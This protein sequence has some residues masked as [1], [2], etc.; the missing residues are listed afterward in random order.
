M[1]NGTLLSEKWIKSSI[2]GTIWAASEIVLG[3]FLHNLKIPF[4][5]TVL[6]SIGL[7]VL[8]STSYK[9]TEKGLFWRAG[10]I[11]AL[12]K[13]ISPSAVIF[14]PMIAIFSQALMLEI[15]TR[16]FGRNIF[17]FLI[18]AIF[19]MTWNLFQ[20]IANYIL[21]YGFDI[22]NIYSELLKYA[23]KQLNIN[24]DLVW[25][26]ILILE[27]IY[28]SIGV[29]ATIIGIRV[30]EKLLTQSQ[31]HITQK[32]YNNNI[33]FNT[34]KFSF[35]YSISWLFLNITFLISIFVLLNYT[36]WIIWTS[37]F[38]IFTLIWIL[39]Y[40]KALKQLSRPRL[41]IYFVIITMLTAFVFN[42]IQSQEFMAGVLVGIQ[43]NVRAIILILGFSVIG[44]EL[45]NPKIRNYFANTTFKQ[46]PMALE[47]S[48]ES[49]PLII[50]TVPEF[51]ILLR[52][53]VSVIYQVISQIEFRLVELKNKL[54]K[55]IFIVSGGIGVGKTTQVQKIVE[56]LHKKNITINGI[57]APRIMNNGETIGYDIVDIES[58]KR[59]V[60]LRNNDD[61]SSS[62]IGKYS[63][64]KIG[65]DMGINA[66][67]KSAN[68]KPDVVVIDEVG[69]LE[70]NNQGWANNINELLNG[71]SLLIFAV[72][73]SFVEQVIQNW[74]LTNFSV[75]K[76]SNNLYRDVSE[77]IEKNLK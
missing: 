38:I 28:A 74:N 72:R 4:S 25:A 55:R 23:Q 20:K 57:Y 50:A 29:I 71:S 37:A 35:D 42:K 13:T 56:L 17:G 6:T 3:S 46:L 39:R 10:L 5:S 32:Y 60:L 7:I 51:K 73:D 8:I 40:K 21:Y 75:H 9:W 44:T 70:L 77:I 53:P 27:S 63:I 62:K 47:L 61:E 43:M 15:F 65:F 36:H 24:I 26:P 22:V 19:A 12:M 64:S 33:K 59:E 49:L 2:V 16:I 58:N 41:W 69:K 52:D 54:K 67:N 66:L 34:N 1:N 30:G 48:F 14:G 11:C 68:N 31:D 18:G 45:Y 76:V